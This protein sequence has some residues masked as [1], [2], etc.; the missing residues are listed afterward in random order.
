MMQH[1]SQPAEFCLGVLMYLGLPIPDT[2]CVSSYPNTKYTS[3][4]DAN[5]LHLLTCGVGPGRMRLHDHMV[6]VWHIAI[7]STG[8][9]VRVQPRGLYQDQCWPD[10]VIPNFQG[11]QDLHLDFS[12]THPGLPS[13]VDTASNSPGAAAAKKENVKDVYRDRAGMFLPLVVEHHC[14]LYRLIAMTDNL[15][16]FIELNIATKIYKNR[17]FRS[18]DLRQLI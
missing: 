7:V 18:V 1:F 2:Q 3:A 14:I 13:N 6:R 15:K 5:G 12:A 16:L 10:I 17:T 4:I 8:L 11:G 9:R